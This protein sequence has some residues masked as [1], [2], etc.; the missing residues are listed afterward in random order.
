MKLKNHQEII[1]EIVVIV[2]QQ[3]NLWLSRILKKKII[4]DN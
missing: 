3:I 1:K 2:T 4:L